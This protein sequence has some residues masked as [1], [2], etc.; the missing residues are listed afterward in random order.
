MENVG[1]LFPALVPEKEGVSL[2]LCRTVP[3]ARKLHLQGV[4]ALY[5]L[6]FAEELRT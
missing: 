1:L 4:E 6:R 2:R 5:A 3:E